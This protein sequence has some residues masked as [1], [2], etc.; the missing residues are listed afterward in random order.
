MIL[1]LRKRI[2]KQ[3]IIIIILNQ[4]KL[5]KLKFNKIEYILFIKI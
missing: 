5:L 4:K 2:I 3:L 1:I